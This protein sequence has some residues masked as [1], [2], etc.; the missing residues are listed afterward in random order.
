MT[1]VTQTGGII[2]SRLYKTPSESLGATVTLKKQPFNDIKIKTMLQKYLNNSKE[3][4]ILQLM[5]DCDIIKT[6]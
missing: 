6:L 5:N 1:G 3:A 4:W 2:A